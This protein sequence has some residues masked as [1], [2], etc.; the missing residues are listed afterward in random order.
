MSDALQEFYQNSAIATKVKLDTYVVIQR[1]Q[2][3][4]NDLNTIMEQGKYGPIPSHA[5]VCELVAGGKTI[6]RGEIIQKEAEW[7]FR[8][9]EL[10]IKTEPEPKPVPPPKTPEPIEELIP[11]E[12]KTGKKSSARHKKHTGSEILT[13]DEVNDLLDA[14][15]LP[16][17]HTPAIQGAKK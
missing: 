15:A 16:R 11:V 14:V 6:A 3:S 8:V 13:A 10:V 5:Q 1:T 7:Y 2:L 17:V 4:P 9:C 12:S